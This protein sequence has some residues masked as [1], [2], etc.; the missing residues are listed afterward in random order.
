MMKTLNEIEN[1]EKGGFGGSMSLIWDICHSEQITTE[2]YVGYRSQL[3]V[4]GLLI[5]ISLYECFPQ[6]TQ[7]KQSSD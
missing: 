6:A 5:F 7:C 1:S 4:I 2:L 3:L